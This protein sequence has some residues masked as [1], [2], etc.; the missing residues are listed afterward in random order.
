[1]QPRR[2]VVEYEFENRLLSAAEMFCSEGDN[3]A[4]RGGWLGQLQPGDGPEFPA[5]LVAPRPVEQ[6][7]LDRENSQSGKLRRALGPDSPQRCD[8]LCER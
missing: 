3:S 1:V 5:I 6:Q 8:R 7:I 2:A 4:A